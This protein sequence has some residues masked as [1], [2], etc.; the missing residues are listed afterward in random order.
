MMST[1]DGAKLVRHAELHGPPDVDGEHGVGEEGGDALRQHQAVEEVQRPLDALVVAA[2][3]VR[4][5]HIVLPAQTQHGQDDGGD[6]RGEQRERE[7]RRE[8]LGEEEAAGAE[9]PPPGG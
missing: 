5:V 3:L 9:A 6:A 8:G 2:A 7:P 4:R 1:P